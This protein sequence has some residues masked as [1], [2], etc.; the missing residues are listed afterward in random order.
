MKWYILYAVLLVWSDVAYSLP[1]SR[2]RSVAGRIFFI[3]SSST[4]LGA[5]KPMPLQNQ[6]YKYERLRR[7]QALA[8][9]TTKPPTLPTSTSAVPQV[10][11]TPTTTRFLDPPGIEPFLNW[12]SV[13]AIAEAIVYITPWL[14]FALYLSKQGRYDFTQPPSNSRNTGRNKRR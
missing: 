4:R 6:A 10:V 11:A 9:I 8:A 5:F 7:T 13:Y 2:T 3:S 1:I 12:G 14:A